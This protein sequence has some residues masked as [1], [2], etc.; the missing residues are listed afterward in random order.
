MAQPVGLQRARLMEDAVE[1]TVSALCSELGDIG[2]G[3]ALLHSW[4][5][6]WVRDDSSADLYAL[7]QKAR[8]VARKGS[9][10]V[11]ERRPR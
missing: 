8:Q 3:R 6:R 9:G 10:K 7:C 2:A 11:R 1:A 4:L 5:L